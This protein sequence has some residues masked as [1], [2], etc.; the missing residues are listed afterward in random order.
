M[1]A[2]PKILKLDDDGFTEPYERQLRRLEAGWK[3]AAPG[4]ELSL[5]Q[6]RLRELFLFEAELDKVARMGASGSMGRW[7]KSPEPD[8]PFRK[9]Q[10]GQ[11]GSLLRMTREDPMIDVLT[12]VTAIGVF[13][14][15]AI[16]AIERRRL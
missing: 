16:D 7:S 14:V 5:A 9:L 4:Q 15:L 3:S 8:S 13:D 6:Y 1:P 12:F 2:F 11:Y 10:L